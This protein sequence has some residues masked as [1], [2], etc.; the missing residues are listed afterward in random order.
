MKIPVKK[1][2]SIKIG[3]KYLFV[4]K[5]NIQIQ[6]F[7]IFESKENGQKAIRLCQK[8]REG[9]VFVKKNH[10]KIIKDVSVYWFG[11]KIKVSNVMFVDS[12]KEV[13]Y[14][15]FVLL[16]GYIKQIKDEQGLFYSPSIFKQ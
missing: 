15:Y 4:Y 10:G 7:E 9:E 14:D 13:G 2:I 3:E 1:K 16:V 8:G 11:K 5:N 12:Y 6:Y